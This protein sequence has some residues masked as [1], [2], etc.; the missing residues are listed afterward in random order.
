MQTTDILKANRSIIGTSSSALRHW[1]DQN[2]SEM[3]TLRGR[4]DNAGIDFSQSLA[5]A[6]SQVFGKLGAIKSP[7]K[8]NQ[9]RIISDI[10]D[11]EL[12]FPL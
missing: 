5:A 9:Q 2:P 11:K 4:P 6:Q 8:S 7:E 12:Y 10:S 3:T 1:K